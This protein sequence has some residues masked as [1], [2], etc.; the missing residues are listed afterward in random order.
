MKN[1]LFILGLYFLSSLQAYAQPAQK[2]TLPIS[3]QVTAS[4]KKVHE[5][6]DAIPPRDRVLSFMAT[7]F[8]EHAFIDCVKVLRY[9][10]Y[11]DERMDLGNWFEDS[12]PVGIISFKLEVVTNCNHTNVTHSFDAKL[13]VF[14]NGLTFEAKNDSQSSDKTHHPL[15]DFFNPSSADFIYDTNSKWFRTSHTK[16]DLIND[17]QTEMMNL[18]ALRDHRAGRVYK[19]LGG[20]PCRD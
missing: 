15:T 3:E 13:T 5:L 7:A 9:K 18:I 19:E 20:G 14:P 2:A 8:Y 6:W 16:I 11:R 1:A 17:V 10:N 4:E 12:S